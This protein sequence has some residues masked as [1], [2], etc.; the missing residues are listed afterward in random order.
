MDH[1]PHLG[2]GPGRPR[3]PE[4]DERILDATLT[5]FERLGWHG[6][7]LDRVAREARTGKTSLYSRWTTKTDLLSAAL[8]WDR[9]RYGRRPDPSQP[10]REQLI[11]D[12]C[13]VA[14]YL[15]GPHGTAWLRFEIESRALPEEF[16]SIRHL[17]LTR[18]VDVRL[19]WL[20]QAIDNGELSADL[21]PHRLLEAIQGAALV[22]ALGAAP[23]TSHDILDGIHEWAVDLVDWQLRAFALV[24]LKPGPSQASPSGPKAAQPS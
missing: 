17:L 1:T 24:P 22:H 20:Q 16:S 7:T 8:V 3:D 2:P 13:A 23:G 10:L 11:D 6:L 21:P 14:Q 12:V 4:V 5:I 15:L 19:T 18:W 9:N